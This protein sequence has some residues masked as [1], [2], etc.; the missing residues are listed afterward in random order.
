[1]GAGW[2]KGIGVSETNLSQAT[3]NSTQPRKGRRTALIVAGALV[4]ALGA[5][6]AIA[7]PRVLHSQRVEEYTELAEQLREFAAERAE[8]E[9]TLYAAVALTHARHSEALS[10]ANAVAALGEA[11]E[12]MLPAEQAQHLGDTG[13]AAVEKLGPLAEVT[14]DDEPQVILTNAYVEVK[15]A[16]ENARA[17][18]QEA[19][20]VLPDAT[21]PGA[22]ADLTVEQA[23]DLLGAPV[24]PEAVPTV[25]DE[26]VTDE[27]IEQLQA[28]LELAQSELAVARQAVDAELAR[29]QELADAMNPVETALHEVAAAIDDY[30]A[31]VEEEAA[32]AEEDVAHKTATAAQHVRDSADSGAL[33]DL[34]GAI[35]A[36]IAAGQQSLTS[37][38]DVVA[39][40]EAAAE[41][42]R[43]AEREAAKKKSS[44]DGWASGGM[45]NY[46]SPMGGGMY[47][48]PCN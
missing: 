17:A 43:K 14:G 30:L 4:V 18:A 31:A 41:A 24:E 5:T 2:S 20:D 44:S 37:H 34:P 16:D 39:A 1:M 40:E 35:S 9:T 28:A 7:V 26:N 42:K 32:K 15:A 23:I 36:Y 29:H 48:A 19:G 22:V 10:L 11:D 13:A 47:M 21:V 33:L 3:T 12:P 45:C 8:V 25:A 38:A 27:A 6:A 46:W